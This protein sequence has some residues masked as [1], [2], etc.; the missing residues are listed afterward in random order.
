VLVETN[1]IHTALRKNLN[2]KISEREEVEWWKGSRGVGVGGKSIPFIVNG[3]WV[4]FIN[5]LCVNS[6]KIRW[7]KGGSS[8]LFYSQWHKV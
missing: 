4:I 5:L 3:F 1:G 7:K 8:L 6:V 2:L